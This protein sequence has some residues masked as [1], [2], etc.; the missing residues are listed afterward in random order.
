MRHVLAVLH[1]PDNT[2]LPN[3]ILSMTRT[4]RGSDTSVYLC[5]MLALLVDAVFCLLALFR[6]LDP[7]RNG[8][9]LDLLQW[10]GE[11]DIERERIRRVDVAPWWMLLENF[12]LRA[13]E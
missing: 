9:D 8:A 7:R 12:V 13:C 5:L 10:S 4:S 11:V 2:C 3:Q 1:D 6:V